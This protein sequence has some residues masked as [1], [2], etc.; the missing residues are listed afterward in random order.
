MEKLRVERG[1]RVLELPLFQRL[2]SAEDG[3]SLARAE[4]VS[5]H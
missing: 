4:S 1:E 3:Y 2:V 5:F